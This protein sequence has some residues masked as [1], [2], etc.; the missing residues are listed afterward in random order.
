MH[1]RT[2]ARQLLW[3][4]GEGLPQDHSLAYHTTRLAAQAGLPEAQAELG[5]RL[6]LGLMPP[7]AAPMT[8][9]A[10][11]SDGED[12]QQ[13]TAAPDMPLFDMDAPQDADSL[14]HYYFAAGTRSSLAGWPS[15]SPLLMTLRMNDLVIGSGLRAICGAD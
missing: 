10:A 8:H 6:G 11:G 13:S 3:P 14:L 7:T 12:A 15:P 4:P 2:Y 9:Q 5:F 1:T